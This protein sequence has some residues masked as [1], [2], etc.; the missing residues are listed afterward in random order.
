MNERVEYHYYRVLRQSQTERE[1]LEVFIQSRWFQVAQENA[2]D[3]EVRV[4]S[5]GQQNFPIERFSKKLKK[6]SPP[7]EP[8]HSVYLAY[9]R[10]HIVI[11]AFHR[12]R[13]MFRSLCLL[14]ANTELNRSDKSWGEHRASDCRSPHVWGTSLRHLEF[15]ETILLSF[16]F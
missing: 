13:K 12:Y 6:V 10:A 7:N 4:S 3:F 1:R 8:R 16:S 5:L 2:I 14:Y 15:K 11:C 9:M